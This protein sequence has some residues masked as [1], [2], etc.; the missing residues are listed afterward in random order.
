MRAAAVELGPYLVLILAGFLPNEV[1]RFLGLILAR[2][3]NEDSQLVIW[4]RAVATAILA[5]VIAKLILFSTGELA[6]IPLW[7]RIGATAC[8][9]LAYMVMKRSVYAG[10]LAGEAALLL[11][12]LIFMP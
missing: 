8:A 12:G 7:V 5:G 9:F 3:L 4:S 6:G 1:W 11:G 2:G 10:V